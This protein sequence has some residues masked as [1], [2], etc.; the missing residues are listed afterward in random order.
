LVPNSATHEPEAMG[1]PALKLASLTTAD[2]VGAVTGP[3][4]MVMLADAVGPNETPL[5]L[6][7]TVQEWLPDV[8]PDVM[9]ETLI[10]AGVVP[11]PGFSFNQ[12]QSVPRDEVKARPEAGFVLVTESF[13]AAGPVAPAAYDPKARLAGAAASVT[14]GAARV[15]LKVWAA[16]CGIE[17]VVS[18]T[19]TA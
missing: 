17:G 15:P 1:P 5:A 14:G 7:E 16:D 9:T 3:P 10:V 11:A 8:A 19:L 4:A 2:M 13:C 12:A 6:S 18:V